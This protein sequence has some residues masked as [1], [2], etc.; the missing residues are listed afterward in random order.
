MCR[1]A[2]RRNT[3]YM[4]AGAS[5]QHHFR[6]MKAGY[7]SLIHYVK[8]FD[9]LY[10]TVDPPITRIHIRQKRT[11]KEEEWEESFIINIMTKSI[12]ENVEKNRFRKLPKFVLESGADYQKR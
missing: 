8:I 9:L 12:E 7:T 1:A 6:D 10:Y 3:M 2:L 11:S 5:P 4:A